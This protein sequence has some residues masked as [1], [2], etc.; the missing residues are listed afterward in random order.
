MATEILKF[1]WK[2]FTVHPKFSNQP[3][4]RKINAF[5][6][7]ICLKDG[8]PKK[9]EYF[10]LTKARFK[11]STKL[12][13]YSGPLVADRVEFARVEISI[14][15]FRTIQ[16]MLGV[17]LVISGPHF[18]SASGKSLRILSSNPRKFSNRI[19]LFPDENYLTSWKILPLV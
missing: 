5:V 9:T 8:A 7:L 11:I 6:H 16:G 1:R 17:P 4:D 13:V 18:A 3:V 12:Q 15:K 2:F 19:R 10:Q 14:Q